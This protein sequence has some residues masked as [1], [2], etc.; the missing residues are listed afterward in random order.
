[1]ACLLCVHVYSYFKVDAPWRSKFFESVPKLVINAGN[2]EFFLPDDD[3]IWWD[4]LPLAFHAKTRTATIS[5][6][7]PLCI[8]TLVPIPVP[9]FLFKKQSIEGRICG[10]GFSVVTTNTGGP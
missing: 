1:M 2:D 6:D 7:L 3:H 8:Y 10:S 4:A 5:I 9:L